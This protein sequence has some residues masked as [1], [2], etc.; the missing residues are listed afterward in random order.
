MRIGRAFGELAREADPT[1]A[2]LAVLWCK[3][4]PGVTA[5]LIGTG[6]IAHLEDLLAIMGMSLDD[7][8]TEACDDLVPPGTHVA[9]FFIQHIPSYL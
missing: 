5:P 4:Q 9:N 2:Q 8:L 7:S 1:A 3:E 6:S